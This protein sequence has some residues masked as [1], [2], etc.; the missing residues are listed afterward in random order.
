MGFRTKPLAL[1]TD[2][3]Q[4]FCTLGNVWNSSGDPIW[5]EIY[6]G[7]YFDSTRP[8]WVGL[9]AEQRS[10]ISPAIRKLEGNISELSDDDWDG[11]NISLKQ[12]AER[13]SQHSYQAI[14]QY[15]EHDYV[16][17]GRY[18]DEKTTT[19]EECFSLIRRWLGWIDVTLR[20]PARRKT[21]GSTTKRATVFTRT[22][23][24]AFRDDVQHAWNYK[25]AVT[26]LDFQPALRASHILPWADYPEHRTDPN[27]GLLL[28]ST[29]DALFDGGFISFKDDGMIKISRFFPK[30]WV[31]KLHVKASDKLRLPNKHLPR[32]RHFL[33][34]HRQLRY[35]GD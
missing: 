1:V 16:W 34:Q 9:V 7:P 8:I 2:G 26:D 5:I 33:T 27:N 3:Q 28:N 6:I 12:T 19:A 25:C 21:K 32:L 30:E 22:A 14:E 15:K 17:L 11:Y 18:F 13:L 31:K 24:N 29:L 4:C 35:L 10:S 20:K 23:Q